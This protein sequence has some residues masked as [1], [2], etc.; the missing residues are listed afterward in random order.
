MLP[1]SSIIVHMHCD[2]PFQNSFQQQQLNAINESTLV[3]TGTRKEEKKHTS[4]SS[5]N[6]HA[7]T[8]TNQ[9]TAKLCQNRTANHLNNSK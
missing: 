7:C 6:S 2:C 3:R 9:V 4:S 5:S 1:S 8:Q